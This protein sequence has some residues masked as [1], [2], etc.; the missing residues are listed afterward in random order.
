MLI[1]EE[2]CGDAE[3]KAMSDLSLKERVAA[4]EEQLANLLARQANGSEQGAM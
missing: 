2:V 1:K 4:L 3:E